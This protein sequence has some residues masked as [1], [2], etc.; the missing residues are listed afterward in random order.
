LTYTKYEGKKRDMR[1]AN[2]T[3]L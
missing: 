2:N 1:Q 3:P